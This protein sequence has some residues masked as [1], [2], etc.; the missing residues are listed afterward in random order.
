[1]PIAEYVL[2]RLTSPDQW[3]NKEKAIMRAY[4][5]PLDRCI[6]LVQ[7][8]IPEE[9]ITPPNGRFCQDFTTITAQLAQV[10]LLEGRLEEA[11]VQFSKAIEYET[12][13]QGDEWPKTERALDLLC[14]LAVVLH[15]LGD[16]EG[17]AE[18]YSS[19]IP[20]SEKLFGHV[21]ERTVAISSQ[22]KSLS[23]RR[24][25]ML[26]HHKSAVIGATDC[27]LLENAQRA[28]A[29]TNVQ[30]SV[31]A[32]AGPSNELVGEDVS[33]ELRGAAYAGDEG[34]VRL[35]LGIQTIN[36]NSTDVQNRTALSCATLRGHE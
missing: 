32:E 4:L 11:R 20:L 16:L 21:D 5:A 12:I 14:E 18:L 31:T 9:E 3:Y 34:M 2:I 19:A 22:F 10:Y 27:K 24:E 30:E 13:R 1:M 17:S 33:A 35:I 29:G 25:V 6:S 26:A 36:P 23:D 7:K 8:H 15:R 28:Q